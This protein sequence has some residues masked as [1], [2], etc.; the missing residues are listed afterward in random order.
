ML[1][2]QYNGNLKCFWGQCSFWL[3]SN[4]NRD[5]SNRA[6]LWGLIF[7]MLILIN[8]LI[9][10]VTID[11]VFFFFNCCTVIFTSWAQADGD[12]WELVCPTSLCLIILNTVIPT[13]VQLLALPPAQSS[14]THTTSHKPCESHT[15]HL[16]SFLLLLFCILWF[17]ERQYWFTVHYIP[18]VIFVFLFNN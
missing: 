14:G 13:T 10:F 15:F 2:V 12:G 11:H 17:L 6:N 5:S 16:H 4:L 8:H 9:C 3:N 1:E 18:S 7:C